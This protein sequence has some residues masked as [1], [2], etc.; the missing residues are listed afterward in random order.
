MDSFNNEKIFDSLFYEVD[1]VFLEEKIS[2]H[3]EL[4][5]KTTISD[6]DTVYR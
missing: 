1:T 4:D 5:N 2:K 3:T 6:D